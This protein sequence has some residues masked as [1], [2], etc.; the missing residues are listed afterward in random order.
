MQIPKLQRAII[1]SDHAGALIQTSKRPIPTPGPNQALIKTAAV[2]LNPCDWK[3]STA[4]PTPGAGCGS[5]YAG[6]VVSLG[7]AV[8]DLREGDRVAGAVHANNPVSPESGAYAEYSVVD[9]DQLWRIP[10]SMSWAEAATIGLCGIGTVGMAAWYNLNLPGTPEKP[11]T[12]NEWILV[13]GA[14]TA[15]G[16]V[17]VQTL[18]R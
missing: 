11:S 18:K 1:Q 2:A 14:S 3:M 16:T 5:D 13:Y 12:K 8:T 4:F 17:A 9:V 7:S 10:D 15:N 6:S